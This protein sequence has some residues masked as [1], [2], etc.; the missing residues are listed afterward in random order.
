MSD[1]KLSKYERENLLLKL[2]K[3]FAF[4]GATIPPELEADGGRI[5]LRAFVFEMSKKRGRLTPED[6][7]EVDRV[8]SAVKR[9]RREII[10]RISREEMA[11]SEA[12]ALYAEARGL[13]RALDTLYNAP[14]PKPSIKE[15][16]NRAKMEDGRRWLN[17]MRKVY[18]GEEKRKRD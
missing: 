10:D 16:A 6:I 12:Q 17:L 18:S 1:E 11:K 15:E 8:I 5:P 2:D 13:D 9:K 3:E 4:A 7:A 14:M